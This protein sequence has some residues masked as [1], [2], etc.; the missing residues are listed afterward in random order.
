MCLVSCCCGGLAAWG[1]LAW[2][3]LWSWGLH[4]ELGGWCDFHVPL[5]PSPGSQLCKDSGARKE[6]SP[7]PPPPFVTGSWEGRGRKESQKPKGKGER[8]QT[9]TMVEHRHDPFSARADLMRREVRTWVLFKLALSSSK[10][11]SQVITSFR[12]RMGGGEVCLRSRQK[13]PWTGQ[14]PSRWAPFWLYLSG[15]DAPLTDCICRWDGRQGVGSNWS[16][17]RASWNRKHFTGITIFM[18]VIAAT[19]SGVP[20]QY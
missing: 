9:I 1:P 7:H 19:I 10:R 3:L 4:D 16:K 2:Q 12:T 8:S 17:N 14:G 20:T 6:A 15:P 18:R 11:T 5:K 13:I